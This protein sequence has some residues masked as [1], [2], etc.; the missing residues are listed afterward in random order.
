MILNKDL[1]S[2]SRKILST[3]PLKT[4]EDFHL[5]LENLAKAYNKTISLEELNQIN[6]NSNREDKIDR[7]GK[8]ENDKGGLESELKGRSE[9]SVIDYEKWDKMSNNIN[10]KEEEIKTEKEKIKKE[11]YDENIRLA[12]IGSSVDHSKVI[13]NSHFHFSLFIS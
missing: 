2:F 12:K 10:A 13:F 11:N 4:E 9:K 5:S 7:S 8:L 3:F 6:K 1:I